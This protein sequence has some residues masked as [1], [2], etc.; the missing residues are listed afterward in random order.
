MAEIF[1][2]ETRGI[3]KPDYTR[4]VS[5][6]KE[7]AG[8]VLKENQHFRVFASD[9]VT[10]DP[11]YPLVTGYT[12]PAGGS[13][14]MRD[15]DTGALLPIIIPQ[16]HTLTII[17]VAYS[18][19]QDILVYGYL[20]ALTFG[21]CVNLGVLG[22]GQSSYENKLREVSTVWYDP[23]AA[24]PHTWDVITYNKGGGDLY[25]GAALLCVEEA[26]GTPPWST[27]K[28]CVCPYCDH[29]QIEPVSATR[30]T[31]QGCGKE[32]MVTNFASLR[33]LGG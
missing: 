5:S 24:F 21:V 19:T 25:G 2:V 6:A 28:E 18:V 16:G 26:V 31:C 29:K 22:G 13:R 27:T 20:D 14:H 15:S 11:I 7:R 33:E 8:I 30:I 23:T 1:V 3:G 17:S 4:E 12:I 32:Y 9:W 10:G